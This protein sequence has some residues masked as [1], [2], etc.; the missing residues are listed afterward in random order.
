MEFKKKMNV[1]REKEKK[2]KYNLCNKVYSKVKD[3][4]AQPLE[5]SYRL[6][7]TALVE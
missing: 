1:Y 5:Y 3:E 6:D 7:E 4:Q 2:N